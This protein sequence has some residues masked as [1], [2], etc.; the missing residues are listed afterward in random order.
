MGYG[1]EAT[2]R[3]RNQYASLMHGLKGASKWTVHLVI[4]V[5]GMCGWVHTK[6]FNESMKLLGVI[7]SQR[8]EV[9]LEDSTCSI[10]WR[11]RL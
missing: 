2:D 11:N 10:S 3:A 5:G 6:T 4:I 7:E 8:D 1:E 9:R